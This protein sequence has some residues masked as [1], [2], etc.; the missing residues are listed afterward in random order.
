MKPERQSPPHC[1]ASCFWSYIN[2]FSVNSVTFNVNL[3]CLLGPGQ[4]FVGV[5]GT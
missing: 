1:E 2:T 3:V 4:V 5:T